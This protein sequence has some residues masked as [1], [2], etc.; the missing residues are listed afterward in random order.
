MRQPTGWKNVMP[1][2]AG[3]APVPREVSHKVNQN[4]QCKR[5]RQGMR[6][7]PTS[8]KGATPRWHH[9]TLNVPVSILQPAWQP[10]SQLS[11]THVVR[12]GLGDQ[13]KRKQVALRAGYKR[14]RSVKRKQMAL[15]A[16][17]K[18]TRSVSCMGCIS[19]CLFASHPV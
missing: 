11:I 9:Q 15:R 13:Q 10:A 16:G 6:M 17:Y 19:K 5:I 2:E 18:R 1:F 12:F 8:N 7:L 14:T 4:A 3:A